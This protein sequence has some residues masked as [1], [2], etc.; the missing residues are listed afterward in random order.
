MQVQVVLERDAETKRYTATVPGLPVVVD[1]RTKKDAVKLVREA[2]E[3]YVEETKGAL[4]TV[5]AELV[6]VNV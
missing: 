3:L 4:P 5:E 1:A 6:T 2:I